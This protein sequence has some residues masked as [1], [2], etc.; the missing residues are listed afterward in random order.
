MAALG[1]NRQISWG[2]LHSMECRPKI[3]RY[4][5]ASLNIQSNDV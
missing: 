4:L 2:H 5:L 1:R 3:E